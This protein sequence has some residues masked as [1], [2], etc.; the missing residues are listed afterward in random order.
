MAKWFR[1]IGAVALMVATSQLFAADEAGLDGK[2]GFAKL[3]ALAGEWTSQAEGEHPASALHYRVTSNGTSVIET[4][5]A[6]TSHEMV[7]M[8]HLDGDDLVATHYC[9]LGNQPKLKLDTKASS[10]SKLVFDFAGG[11]NV[12]PDK[13]SHMHAQR[14]TLRDKDHLTTEWDAYKDGTKQHTLKVEF[15]R[16]REKK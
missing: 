10:A 7:T 2:W 6:G 12:D 9:A 11:T 1:A 4:L 14:Y 16:S 3:K 13:D 5:F 8:Y 15:S